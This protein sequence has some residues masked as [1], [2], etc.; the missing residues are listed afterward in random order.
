[1]ATGH[2]AMENTN[3]MLSEKSFEPSLAVNAMPFTPLQPSAARSGPDLFSSRPAVSRQCTVNT[4]N[5]EQPTRTPIDPT[6]QSI[7]LP[8]TTGASHSAT[9][10][11]TYTASLRG[12]R[13]GK[14]LCYCSGFTDITNRHFSSFALP[15]P[16]PRGHDLPIPGFMVRANSQR[17]STKVQK[18]VQNA[19]WGLGKVQKK[20]NRFVT[21]CPVALGRPLR[22]SVA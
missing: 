15:G 13:Q 8:V 6:S 22:F 21:F 16:R 18:K 14:L 4:L 9:T 19:A 11:A 10:P 17:S 12:F 20:N 2:D 3:I 1:M 5:Q 7:L